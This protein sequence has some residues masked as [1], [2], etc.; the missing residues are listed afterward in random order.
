MASPKPICIG[1]LCG[2]KTSAFVGGKQA[3]ITLRDLQLYS[4]DIRIHKAKS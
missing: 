2:E 1:L 4:K 3:E